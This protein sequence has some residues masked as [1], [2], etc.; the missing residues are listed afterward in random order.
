MPMQHPCSD[1]LL[2]ILF[3]QEWSCTTSTCTRALIKLEQHV[4]QKT[5]FFPLN[6]VCNATPGPWFRNLVM[7]PLKTW[8]M[9]T[10]P[11]CLFCSFFIH[12]WY[13]VVAW[14]LHILDQRHDSTVAEN[15]TIYFYMKLRVVNVSLIQHLIKDD[16]HFWSNQGGK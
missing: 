5:A 6:S 7:S 3:I 12:R 9:L 8:R 10:W 14:Y 16:A 13:I 4:M 15:E 1:K 2:F 11:F